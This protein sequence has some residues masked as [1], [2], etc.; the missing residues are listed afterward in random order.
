MNVDWMV[1]IGDEFEPE[2]DALPEAVQTEM[3]AVTRLL[4]HFGPH[5]GRPRVDTLHGSR[6]ANMKELRFRA[7][8]GEWRVAF[9]FDPKRTAIL[10]VAGDKSGGSAKRFYRGLLRKADA[11]RTAHRARLKKEGQESW[12]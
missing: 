2:F 10:L 3:L 5:L 8:D 9:A 6:H 7:A 4:Q 11:Q 1:A 12:L